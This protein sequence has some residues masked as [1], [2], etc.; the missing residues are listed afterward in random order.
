M[1]LYNHILT[2]R[3]QDVVV[4]P[5]RQFQEMVGWE[6]GGDAVGESFVEEDLDYLAAVVTVPLQ[7]I[8]VNSA[9]RFI[10]NTEW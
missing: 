1:T 6:V 8:H 10:T 3:D 7:I 9:G 5:W 2:L 4:L